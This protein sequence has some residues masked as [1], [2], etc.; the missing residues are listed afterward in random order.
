MKRNGKKQE[1]QEQLASPN[2][3]LSRW[4]FKTF[5]CALTHSIEI[6]SPPYQILVNRGD[7]KISP[8]HSPHP[9]TL[10][11]TL[12]PPKKK[13]SILGKPGH[14]NQL[15]YLHHE[16]V[17]LNTRSLLH[18]RRISKTQIF[19][20]INT[21]KWFWQRMMVLFKNCCSVEWGQEFLRWN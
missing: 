4:I 11:P 5:Q 10:R 9:H 16:H 12:P 14:S 8:S 6:C 20:E 21:Y 13:T 7:L 15:H 18:F 19:F 2:C 1:L 3:K 17:A